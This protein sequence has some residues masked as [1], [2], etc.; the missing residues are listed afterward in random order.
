M[1]AESYGARVFPTD[2]KSKSH[3][4]RLGDAHAE[5][6]PRLYVDADVELGTA[7]A[8]ALAAALRTPGVLAA[9][10]QRS[11]TMDGSAV[12]VRM[13][14]DVW[15]QLPTVQ[16]GLFGRGVVG[17][18]AAGH[19]RLASLPDVMNDDLAASVAFAPAERRIVAS[20][21]VRVHPPR[22]TGDLLRRRVRALTGTAQL[23]TMAGTA[24][25][26][27]TRADLLRVVRERPAIAPRM[28]VFLGVTAIARWRARR[29][30]RSGDYTTWLRDESSRQV[31]IPT[32]RRDGAPATAKEDR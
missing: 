23:Q 3:A 1:I 8:R 32:Q 17:V 24:E 20:A 16:N 9:A 12:V 15:Q 5:G 22:A 4:M 27:T 2:V 14:Y 21:R 31:D 28:A 10:P 13:Y 7:D 29:P 18:S 30:I 6:F 11:F 19:E 26:R 25:A